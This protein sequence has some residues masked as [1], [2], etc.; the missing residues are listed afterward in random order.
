MENYDHKKIEEKW[1]KEWADA[2]LYET[3]NEVLGKEN[4]YSLVEFPYPSGDLHVGHWYAFAVPDIFARFKRMSGYNVLYPIGFDSFGLPAENAA[5]KRGL[6][7]KKWT[8]SNIEYMREQ[9]RSMGASF[10]WSREL[11][12]SDPAYYKWTQ[13]I[14]TKFFEKGLAYEKE[15]TVNWCPSCN[16]VLANEQVVDGTCERCHEEVEQRDLKQWFLRITDYAERLLDDLDDLAWPK[17]IKESQK[18]WIGKSSGAEF[19]FKL[20]VAG[21]DDGKHSVHVFTTRPDTFFGVTFLV[22]SPEKAREWMKVGWNAPQEVVEYVEKSLKRSELERQTDEKEKT[23]V[24]TEVRAIHPATG[25]EICVWVADY[26]LA[27]YGTGAVMAVPA[28][29]DRDF[30]FAEKFELPIRQVI[31]REFETPWFSGNKS[32][33]V[34]VRGAYGIIRRKEDD[35]VLLQLAT[36]EGEKVY[37]FP[38]GTLDEGEH[39]E[40]GLIRE[41]REEVGYEFKGAGREVGNSYIYHSGSFSGASNN[42][43]FI[44]HKKTFELVFEECVECDPEPDEYEME[45][46]YEWHTPEDALRLTGESDKFPGEYYML[47]DYFYPKVYTETGRLIES[48]EYSGLVSEEAAEKITET[49]G[50]KQTTYRLRDWSVGRQRYWGCPIPI[51]YDPDG[52]PHLIPEEHLPWILPEDVDFKP[53]GEAPLARSKELKDRTEKIFGK[54]WTPAVDTMDTFVDSSWYFLR[55]FDPA[56]EEELAPKEIQKKWM[57]VDYY[58]GGAEHTT[59]H[60]LYSRFFFKAMNDVGLVE[61]S[62]PYKVRMNR[63]LILGPDGQK[64]SKSRG[65]VINPD[66]HVARVGADV[67][68]MYLA[69]IGPYN[70]VGT[71][72]WD[73]G[74][75][76]GIRRFLERVWSLSDRVGEE[77]ADNQVLLHETI[78]RVG[79]DIER[80]KFNTAIS[81]LMEFLNGVKDASSL[82]LDQYKVFLQL[83]APFAPHLAEELWHMV[84]ENESIHLCSW[85]SYNKSVLEEKKIRIVVQIDGKVRHSFESTPGVEKSELERMAR[86]QKEVQ[87]RLDGV[88]IGKVIVVPDRLINFVTKR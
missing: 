87:N 6:D 3:P 27:S 33:L 10:D 42:S 80:L 68:R 52:A 76:A 67:V 54:G 12:T 28:H 49:F 19:E 55:Y 30:E 77:D 62:E 20:K 70:E 45:F 32:N 21:Q 50:K 5:I 41:I 8:D 25:E 4:F 46:E 51:V 7:P 16:T 18:N 85:P 31:A 58:S 24:D 84:G 2:K 22:I 23:G 60:L 75:I 71:Y 63:G 38:G 66:E 17:E 47:K 53:T 34:P 1:Q 43:D 15:A 81:A 26:V 56:N 9:I 78:K 79:E 64:M 44:R 83:L 82:S 59:M 73:M 29:D 13:Y 88:E 69:F 35:K 65:N 86:E 39:W 14:F 61:G 36:I 74:G 72:P 37:R 40:E 57:P 48:G 11:K